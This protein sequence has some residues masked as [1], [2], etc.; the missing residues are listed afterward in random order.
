[1]DPVGEHTTRGGIVVDLMI[2]ENV[3]E[4]LEGIP[5]NHHARCQ[6][7]TRY[8]HGAECF[9]LAVTVSIAKQRVSGQRIEGVRV[10][11]ALLHSEKRHRIRY[12]IRQAVDGICA[13]QKRGAST[14]NER[15]GIEQITR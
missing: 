11:S 8:T 1:M 15:G 4:R 14:G 6:Q 13:S 5:T 9:H 3:L 7:E 12:Q 2:H 10:L